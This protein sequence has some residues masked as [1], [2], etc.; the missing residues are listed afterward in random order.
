MRASAA[1]RSEGGFRYLLDNGSVFTNAHYE[2]ANTETIVGHATLATGAHPSV[3]GMTGNVWHDAVAD[4]L[5]YNI[6]DSESLPLPVRDVE[7]S[8]DQVDPE[9]AKRDAAFVNQT[10]AAEDGALVTSIQRSIASG[11]NE[12]F[13]FGHFESAIVHFHRTL[14]EALD[15]A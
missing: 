11:A 7:S 9:S 10:G 4:E 12:F 15:R 5:A 3:H 8:G 6:E 14:G 2:H 1:L 13:T